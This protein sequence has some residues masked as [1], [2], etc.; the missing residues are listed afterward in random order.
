MSELDNFKAMLDRAEVYYREY[1]SA[2]EWEDDGI[3]AAWLDELE[4][5]TATI[6]CVMPGYRCHY[7]A[8][9]DAEG[10]LISTG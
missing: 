4:P 2:A 3:L 7:E 8:N 9:F 10:K 1:T 5:E 6:M